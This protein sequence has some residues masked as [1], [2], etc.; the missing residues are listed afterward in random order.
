MLKNFLAR[1]RTIESITAP[2]TRIVDKLQVHADLHTDKAMAHESYAAHH[3]TQ[4]A[5][6][7]SET[8]RAKEQANKFASFVR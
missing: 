1:R 4:A 7:K 6:S 2:I 8:E 5:L 3:Q